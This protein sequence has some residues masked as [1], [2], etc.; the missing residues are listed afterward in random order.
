MFTVSKY[1]IWFFKESSPAT[2]VNNDTSDKEYEE[3]Q[4]EAH[5]TV[6]REHKNSVS[7]DRS[8]GSD[9]GLKSPMMDM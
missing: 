8:I 1:L 5:L 2:S 7:P 9:K 3:L 6:S 4:N